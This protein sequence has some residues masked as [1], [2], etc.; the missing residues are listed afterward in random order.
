MEQLYLLRAFVAAAQHRSFSR[1]AESLGVTTGSISKAIAKLEAST[2]TRLLHR[3]TRSVTLTEEAQWYYLS[4]RRLLEE[5]DETNRRI[6]QQREVD[7]GKLRLVVH[8][9]L[10][11][12]TLS[13]FL[14]RYRT[15]APNVNLMVSIQEGPLNLF[16]GKFDMAIQP[17]DLVE[18]SAVIR[19]SL[20]NSSRVIVATP[21]YLAQ[22]G[23]PKRVSDLSQHV[24][25]MPPHLRQRNSDEIEL[26]EDNKPVQVIPRSS[27]D[28]NDIFLRTA[29]KASAGI[30]ALPEAMIRDDIDVGNLVPV[31]RNCIAS[32]EELEL[33]LFYAHRELLPARF[34]TF[35]DFCTEFFRE[36]VSRTR[37]AAYAAPAER[38]PDS[39][40]DL[41]VA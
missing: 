26:R 3:T 15:F 22:H 17:S 13:K 30:A 19:R 34:R 11:A 31:L 33:C 29:V 41:V 14:A 6:T 28:G 10:T 8:P 1:A 20:L 32:D 7:S 24:L 35:I 36:H 39:A 25:L 2:H 18:Q 27:I 23:T 9:V 40:A 12:E 38:T 16:D 37:T 21:R 5:L 4:C